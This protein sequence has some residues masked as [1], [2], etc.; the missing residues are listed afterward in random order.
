MQW[1]SWTTADS[2]IATINSIL[3]TVFEKATRAGGASSQ[4]SLDA[5]A[6]EL[7]GL[8]EEILQT[9]NARYGDK[10]PV[11]RFGKRRRAIYAGRRRKSAV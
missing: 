8:K 1:E 5:I 7:G 4:D 3:E 2:N 10:F 11:F 6:E 9:M